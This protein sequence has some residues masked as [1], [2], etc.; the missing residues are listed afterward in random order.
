MN[1]N[2]LF[3]SYSSSLLSSF[4]FRLLCQIIN[5]SSCASSHLSHF[6]R[7]IINIP[8]AFW[9]SMFVE[10]LVLLFQLPPSPDQLWPFSPHFRGLSSLSLA[11]PTQ[12]YPTTIYQA[13]F[14]LALRFLRPFLHRE[15]FASVLKLRAC[16]SP[17]TALAVTRNL[18]CHREF[19]CT[20]KLSHT[21]PLSRLL[22]L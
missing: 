4:L 18:G 3:L 9:M 7:P 11:F 10:L 12:G 21:C 2:S 13:Q 19:R 8:F 16:S 1:S 22:I 17:L 14:V 5:C 20:A 6:L 15:V